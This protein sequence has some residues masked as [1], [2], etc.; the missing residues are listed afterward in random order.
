MY[1]FLLFSSVL[2]ISRHHN[3]RPPGSRLPTG[4][5][6]RIFF[7]HIFNSTLSE[8]CCFNP[9]STVKHRRRFSSFLFL[10]LFVKRN[11]DGK[12][13]NSSRNS[14]H[15]CYYISNKSVRRRIYTTAVTSVGGGTVLTT[16]FRTTISEKIII[17]WKWKKKKLQYVKITCPGLV[18][19]ASYLSQ[20]SLF[21]Q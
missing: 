18:A 2:W 7:P 10:V 5:R 15:Y 16:R 9:G 6:R 20:I 13:K 21:I 17:E 3:S 4:S 19:A 12:K 1:F 14:H 11:E 8:S